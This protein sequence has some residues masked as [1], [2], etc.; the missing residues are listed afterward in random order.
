MDENRTSQSLVHRPGSK[1]KREMTMEND[2]P[3]KATKITLAS[4]AVSEEDPSMP[5]LVCCYATLIQGIATSPMVYSSYASPGLFW[6]G[7]PWLNQDH[8]MFDFPTW[9]KIKNHTV[10]L[11]PG[12]AR[13]WSSPTVMEFGS[14][15]PLTYHHR[16]TARD[17]RQ[18]ATEAKG[19]Q[20]S[21]TRSLKQSKSFRTR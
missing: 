10:S 15:I 19:S 2:R 8:S 20:S 12:F 17:P 6:N 5:K 7:T 18:A 16:F 14:L 9:H 11:C 13:K 4:T 1:R 3:S 21:S